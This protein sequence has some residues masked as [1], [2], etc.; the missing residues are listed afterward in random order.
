MKTTKEL[1]FEEKRNLALEA[2]NDYKL[3]VYTLFKLI[4]TI[5]EIS[6]TRYEE[7]YIA[8]LL[9]ISIEGFDV[10]QFNEGLV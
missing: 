1:T 8:E 5:G 9:S 10:E 4:S 6:W 2:V 3:G 7:R